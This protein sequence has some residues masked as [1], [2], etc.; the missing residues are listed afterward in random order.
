MVLALLVTLLTGWL[1]L[2]LA[3]GSQGSA[4]AASGASSVKSSGG[5]ASPLTSGGSGSDQTQTQVDINEG[6]KTTVEVK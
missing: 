1:V 4:A 6:T 3:Q 5:S 2:S